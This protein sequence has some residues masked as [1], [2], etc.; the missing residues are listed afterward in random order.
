[1]CVSLVF[2]SYFVDRGWVPHDEG[3]LAHSAERVL[4]GE[5]PHRDFEE[6]YTGGLTFL[7]A[8]AFRLFGERLLSMRWM[9]LAASALMIPAVYLIAAR[10]GIW[11]LAV[12]TA[13]C[14]LAWSLPNYFAGLPSWYVLILTVL[15]TLALLQ[16]RTS[17]NRFWLVGAG[18]CGG[19][20]I[21]MKITGLYFVAAGLLFLLYRDQ[22]R[23]AGTGA[24]ALSSGKSPLRWAGV[25]LMLIIAAGLVGLEVAL[26]RR[27]L[28]AMEILHFVVP[29]AALGACLVAH[30]WRVGFSGPRLIRLAIDAA[31]FLAGVAGPLLLLA[32]VYAVQGAWG[33]LIHGVFVLPSLRLELAKAPLPPPIS[34]LPV[35]LPATILLPPCLGLRSGT[36]L[37]VAIKVLLLITLGLLVWLWAMG[38]GHFATFLS[39]R[40]LLPVVVIGACVLLMRRGAELGPGQR[41]ELFLLSA[42]AAL[43]SLTQYPQSY[44]IYFCY[45][46]PLVLLLIH[47]LAGAF[48]SRVRWAP[49]AVLGCYLAFGALVLN[50]GYG[51]DPG[52]SLRQF[53]HGLNNDRGGLRVQREAAEQY[54]QLVQAVRELTPEGEFIYAAPDCPEVYFL[55]DRRNPTPTMFDFFDQ[56]PDRADRILE[57]LDDK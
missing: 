34:L 5:L 49:A 13:F 36:V 51:T 1:M 18:V 29:T 23:A 48:P 32:V 39:L 11:R 21:L 53:A 26:I 6:A 30:E 12:I 24:P 28:R 19:L 22:L 52:I 35:L 55:A 44:A 37:S 3:L 14:C 27:D 15:G 46:A 17:D 42:V 33:D 2:L 20:A 31:C 43:S 47:A 8:A 57:L 10:T 4:A 16:V 25:L 56:Q 54:D 9:L 45:C 7:H 38:S 41:Q 50:S 40:G